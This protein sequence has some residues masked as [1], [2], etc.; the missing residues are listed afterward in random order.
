MGN[1]VIQNVVVS[2]MEKTDSYTESTE[3]LNGINHLQATNLNGVERS[4]D[5]ENQPGVGSSKEQHQ[6]QH[7]VVLGMS[8]ENVS[9]SSPRQRKLST[10][11]HSPSSANSLDHQQLSTTTPKKSILATATN[12]AVSP[13]KE[14]FFKLAA[15]ASAKPSV[16]AA[17]APTHSVGA[18]TSFS[19]SSE[20]SNSS[21]S[22]DFISTSTASGCSMNKAATHSSSSSTTSSSANTNSVSMDTTASSLSGSLPNNAASLASIFESTFES[23]SSAASSESESEL[24]FQEL[25]NENDDLNR[26]ANGECVPL[27]RLARDTR[28]PTQ[29]AQ[30]KKMRDEVMR[31]LNDELPSGASADQDSYR[32]P[33]SAASSM[34][35]TT[36]SVS[37]LEPTVIAPLLRSISISSPTS[38]PP[39]PLAPF[40]AFAS[41]SSA[42]SNVSLPQVKISSA[43]STERSNTSSSVASSVSS[44]SYNNNNSKF[45]SE[46]KLPP[47]LEYLLD[48]PH[49]D[50]ETAALHGWNPDDRSLNIFVKE[51]DPFTLHRHPVAQSTDCIRTKYGYTKGKL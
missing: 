10:A 49:A 25:E 42:S 12:F 44:I 16:V 48:M 36:S 31:I 8:E 29:E 14:K 34:K 28:L 2:Q 19:S 1:K 45:S 7:Q 37:P 50:F 33:A 13:L 15:A 23:S 3:N 6:Q 46:C 21:E 40:Q 47:R 24:S 22:S 9:G 18:V 26:L 35:A 32:S 38:E 39:Q 20:S 11:N 5:E 27:A 30:K 51:S 17:A 41:T 43:V 4:G